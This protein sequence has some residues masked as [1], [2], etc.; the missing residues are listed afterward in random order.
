MLVLLFC[1]YNTHTVTSKEELRFFALVLVVFSSFCCAC[2]WPPDIRDSIAR[3]HLSMP[4]QYQ[5]KPKE[6]QEND[7]FAL[8]AQPCGV[9][10]SDCSR[11]LICWFDVALKYHAVHQ[12]SSIESTS[13]SPST[14]THCALVFVFHCRPTLAAGVVVVIVTTAQF[15][16]VV[17]V[18][19]NST[20]CRHTPHTEP[21]PKSTNDECVRRH[22]KDLIS[23]NVRSVD[24]TLTAHTT[25]TTHID[26][27]ET[28]CGW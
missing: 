2:V 27:T 20:S 1:S 24:M 10:C 5:L 19:T 11:M 21:P 16:V 6:K 26:T 8:C 9:G 22:S 25:H 23:I 28:R 18:T 15:I 14:H 17:F 7:S 13:S 3:H 4:I 12:L